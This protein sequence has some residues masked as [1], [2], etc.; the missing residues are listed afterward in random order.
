MAQKF[1]DGSGVNN[2]RVDSACVRAIDAHMTVI[3][4]A[5]AILEVMDEMTIPGRVRGPIDDNDSM[6]IA[7]REA[8]DVG[9]TTKRAPT[10][11]KKS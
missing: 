7:L 1:P 6:V 4:K 9:Q 5:D 2:S 10:E 8:R 11:D 3:N